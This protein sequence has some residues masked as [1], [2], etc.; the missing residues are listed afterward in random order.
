MTV[1]E[2]I[3]CLECMAIDMTGAMAGLSERNPMTDVLRQRLDAINA[4][5]DAL[6]A[7]QEAEKNEPLTLEELKNHLSVRHPHDIEPLYVVFNPPIPLDYAP[8]WLGAYNLSQLIASNAD[9]YGKTLLAY[10][11]KPKEG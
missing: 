1:K 11:H 9:N 2:A 6:R 5:K 8:R 7:Q 3:V 10:R 4:A